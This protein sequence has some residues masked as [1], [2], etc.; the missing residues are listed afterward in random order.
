MLF[1]WLFVIDLLANKCDT[2]KNHAI[3]IQSIDSHFNMRITFNISKIVYLCTKNTNCASAPGHYAPTNR[4]HKQIGFEIVLDPH[5]LCTWIL[6]KSLKVL[7]SMLSHY[8]SET[9]L[10]CS[11]SWSWRQNWSHS[12]ITIANS[13]NIICKKRKKIMKS[14]R[15]VAL[16]II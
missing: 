6:I 13:K 15:F 7:I 2:R 1:V 11:T 10:K 12:A 5:K 16:F 9:L 3:Y 8:E 4:N 14:S